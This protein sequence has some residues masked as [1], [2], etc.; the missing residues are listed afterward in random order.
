MNDVSMKYIFKDMTQG[1]EFTEILLSEI[2]GLPLFSDMSFNAVG[3]YGSYIG[4]YIHNST[5]YIKI[6]AWRNG[7]DAKVLININNEFVLEEFPRSDSRYY[8]RD[9]A[10]DA[11]HIYNLRHVYMY[12][13]I[14]ENTCGFWFDDSNRNL[15]WHPKLFAVRVYDELNDT[16]DMTILFSRNVAR[17]NNDNIC[18]VYPFSNSKIDIKNLKIAN[19]EPGMSNTFVMRQLRWQAYL[20]PDVYIISGGLFESDRD[21]ITIDNNTYIHMCNDIYL[22]LS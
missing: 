10:F 16:M 4:T 1:S 14:S 12:K 22:K 8:Y 13:A 5:L 3:S 15:T 9:Y 7:Y 18:V 2:G 19:A 11:N 6:G 21:V 17:N 20:F